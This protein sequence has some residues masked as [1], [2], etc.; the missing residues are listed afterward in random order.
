[1]LLDRGMEGSDIGVIVFYTAQKEKI[2]FHLDNP[3]PRAKLQVI[4]NM[5]NTEHVS[6]GIFP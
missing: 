5:E 6:E 1:M 2:Q 3:G 4:K